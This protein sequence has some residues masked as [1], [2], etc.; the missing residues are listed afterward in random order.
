[1][2]L[3][4]VIRGGGPSG[5]DVCE[6]FRDRLRCITCEIRGS[7]PVSADPPTAADLPA[8]QIDPCQACATFAD[9][10]SEIDH[11][12]ARRRLIT[13]DEQRRL[14]RSVICKPAAGFISGFPHGI[15]RT[16][17]REL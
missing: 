11:G 12:R 15:P 5:A 10:A 4:F 3:I 17:N 16:V 6:D 1:M 8:L 2:G 13:R 14:W 9:G 7:R